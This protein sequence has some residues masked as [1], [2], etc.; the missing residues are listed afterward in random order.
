MATLEKELLHCEQCGAPMESSSSV[1]GCL[2]C[3]LLG[4]SNAAETDG[5]RYQHYEIFLRDDDTLCELGRGAMGVT[6]RAL[7]INL[8]SPVAL[9]VISGR[10]SDNREARER[11]RREARVAA[12]LRHPNVASVFHFGETE[13]HQCFYAMELIEGE[14]LEARVRRDGPLPAPMALDV[15][16]QVTRALIAAAPHGLV[17]RDLKPSNIMLLANDSG[18]TDALIVKVIDFGLAK[19]IAETPNAALRL[20]ASFSGTPEFASP[21]QFNSGKVSLDA[22]SDI[23]SL[24]ATLWYLLC[25]KAPFVGDMSTE[26]RAEQFHREPPWEQ[27]A[28]AKVPS[29]VAAL[30]RSMLAPNP[31]VRPQSARELLDAL[32]TCREAVEVRPRRRRQFIAAGFA[33]G[34]LVASTF[35]LTSYLSRREQA[36]A[37]SALP[38]KSIAVLPFENQSDSKEDVFFAAGMQD[39]VLTSLVKIKDLK[40]V[41]R[42][43]VMGY[44]EPSKR[45]LREIGQQLGVAHVLEGSVRR[46][47]DRVLLRVSLTDTRDDHQLWAERF[48]RTLAGAITLQADL[49]T[50]IAAVLQAKLA[51]QEKESL[52]ARS[53]ENPDAYLLYLRAR[54]RETGA[55]KDKPDFIAAEQLYAQAIALDPKFALALA[56]ASIATSKISS[57]FGT[58]DDGTDAARISRAR[59]EA[60]EAIR[61][62]P[63]LGEG[64]LARALCFLMVDQNREAAL[65]ELAIAETTA[66]NEPEIFRFSG[67]IYREQG[68]WRDAIANYQRALDLDPGNADTAVGTTR[69]YM[70]VRDWPAATRTIS[71]AIKLESNS[72]YGLLYLHGAQV[73]AGDMAAARATLT[74]LPPDF[75]PRLFLNWDWTMTTRDFDA[76]QKFVEAMDDGEEKANCLAMTA[77]AR[78]NVELAHQLFET[79]RP[80]AETKVRDQPNFAERH[81]SLGSLYACLGRKEDAIR[82]SLRAIDVATENQNSNAVVQMECNLAQVYART[83]EAEQAISL[84]ERLLTTPG[85]VGVS[86]GMWSITHIELRLRW[87]WDPL[88]SNPRF[89]KIVEAPEPKTIY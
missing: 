58:V 83:G 80:A 57:D 66:P 55:D 50:E 45:N 29:P 34:L 84:I 72:G 41:G 81:A 87:E 23:Y 89:Q 20:Q 71:R 16:I 31:D 17:H 61:L 40:V 2:N 65:K 10:F 44:R 62:D 21:E 25:G 12:Q 15:A 6:Y 53:T 69:T 43:S 7:D 88:R 73:Y 18:S 1:L 60:E 38:E 54:A 74:K 30:L 5:R 67:V 8:D 39:E 52:E 63:T 48:D 59:A 46:T 68:R 3:L 24:G 32:R 49:A 19:A 75:G 13:T 22:R 35:G 85:A 33:L 36:N 9:K 14:T 28:A 47:A 70:L 79:L 51:P 78:G 82:E 26:L 86:Y 4:G 27:L 76:A 11:F 37:I 77:L 64:H 56:R 42:S